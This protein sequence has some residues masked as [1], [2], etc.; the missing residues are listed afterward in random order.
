MLLD[1]LKF[2]LNGCSEIDTIQK[3][4]NDKIDNKYIKGVK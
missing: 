4:K 1:N 2:L 3:K